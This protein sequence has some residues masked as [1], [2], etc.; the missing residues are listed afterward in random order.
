VVSSLAYLNLF[1]IKDLIV[2]VVLFVPFRQHLLFQNSN[3]S[4]VHISQQNNSQSNLSQ[5]NA[6]KI[7]VFAERKPR[8][9]ETERYT[10]HTQAELV[11]VRKNTR[12]EQNRIAGSKLQYCQEC[13]RSS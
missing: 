2:I 10:L 13:L 1:R 5:L 12:G 8:A 11:Q 7:G 9:P 6:K 3:S 4:P